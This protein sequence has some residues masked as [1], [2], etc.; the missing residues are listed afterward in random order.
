MNR[1]PDIQEVLYCYSC[2]ILITTSVICAAFRWWHICSQ[3]ADNPDYYYPARRSV[4]TFLLWHLLYIP[5]MLCPASPAVTGY[6]SCVELILISSIIPTVF[7]KFFKPEHVGAFR[8]SSLNYVISLTFTALFG[9]GLLLFP[10]F[11]GDMTDIF[12]VIVGVAALLYCISLTSVQLWLNRK[13]DSYHLNEY[14]NE[15]DFPYHFAKRVAMTPWIAIALCWAI[16]F[17]E[18]RILMAV[19][20]LGVSV[21]SVYYVI[22]VLH[23]QRTMIFAV[24]D[25]ER[26]DGSPAAAEDDDRERDTGDEVAEF[27]AADSDTE[28]DLRIASLRPQLIEICRRRY[29]EP[30]L[31]RREIISEFDY[32]SR[33]LAGQIISQYGFYA[34]INT[35]RLEH[36]RLYAASHPMETK[37][38][39]AVNSGFKDRFAMRH[40][41]RK[42]GAGISEMLP[43]FNPSVS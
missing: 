30:H 32:G 26:A 8:R 20:W 5:V 21:L 39:V 38:S 14:S 15:D 16:F 6:A 18:S 27:P 36:A 31:T 24:D 23:P 13:I 35:L 7:I 19:A 9:A 2:V 12:R 28:D 42:I 22:M 29:L 41:E 37:E 4:C 10:D 33:T 25:V 17:T 40:A 3:C 1:Y 11:L 43:G 34:M